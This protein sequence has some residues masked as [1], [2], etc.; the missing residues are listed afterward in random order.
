MIEKL[1]LKIGDYELECKLN[2]REVNWFKMLCEV[3]K[4]RGEGKLSKEELIGVLKDL[5]D[6]KMM[7]IKELI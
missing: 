1:I 7:I 4:L 2:S 5:D 6:I 3:V